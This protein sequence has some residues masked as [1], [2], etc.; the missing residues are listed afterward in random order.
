MK[1]SF[2]ISAVIALSASSYA[3]SGAYTIGVEATDY[4]PVSKGDTGEYKG[5]ARDLLDAFAT[6]YGHQFTY[7]PVPVARLYDEF[8]VKKSV[9]FKFPDNGYWAGDAKKGI[10]LS[11]SKGLVSVTDGTL[12][13]PANKGKS[14]SLSKLGTLRGFTPFPYLDQIKDKKVTVAEANSADAAISMGEA[15]RVEGVY[16]GILAANYVMTEVMKKPGILVFDD[17][18]PKSTGDFSLS[19]IA[20]ADV[21]KQMDEFLV[22]E[23]DTVTKLKAKYKIKE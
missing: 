14:S 23:K 15:G 17:K 21:I 9:D 18:L 5:Y 6:K 22:K 8:L 20:H 1:I 11:Y 2:V 10:T 7:K 13:L 16:M 19:T 3:W 4:L 12:V